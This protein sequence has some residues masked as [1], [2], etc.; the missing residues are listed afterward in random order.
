MDKFEQRYGREGVQLRKRMA[1]LAKVSVLR[2]PPFNSINLE[3]CLDPYKKYLER[4]SIEKQQVL[5][6]AFIKFM[7][8]IIGGDVCRDIDTMAV[9]SE[10]DDEFQRD[11]ASN[12]VPP[13]LKNVDIKNSEIKKI[14]GELFNRELSDFAFYKAGGNKIGLF[15]SN[16]YVEKLTIEF[17][18]GT[19]GA[20]HFSVYIG[21][22]KPG[23]SVELSAVLCIKKR[24]WS[25]NNIEQCSSEVSEVVELIKLLLPQFEKKIASVDWKKKPQGQV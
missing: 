5:L 17:D 8:F 3:S 7:E 21:S 20:G 15:K 6:D 18:L 12:Y 16:E 23:Y 22:E 14:I 10:I 24:R 13:S 4:R 2:Q 11:F 9:W 19:F 1:E 25:Y